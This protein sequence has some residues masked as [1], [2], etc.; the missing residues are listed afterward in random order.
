MLWTCSVCSRVVYIEKLFADG[1][2]FVPPHL[3]SAS[4]PANVCF[5]SWKTIN[6]RSCH[7]P[8]ENVPPKLSPLLHQER[9][10]GSPEELQHNFVR[11]E[12][13]NPPLG[14]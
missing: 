14:L 13:R 10:P 11:D 8:S 4:T 2:L 12:R 9:S 7:A 5:S 1:K 6:W 3:V